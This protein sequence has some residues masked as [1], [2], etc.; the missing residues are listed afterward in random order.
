MDRLDYHLDRELE[1]LA[2]IADG[3]DFAEGLEGFF[4]K[5]PARF[6]RISPLPSGEGK[7]EGGTVAR[8]G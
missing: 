1:E 5:R 8:K 4:E 7:G 3:G 2:R 6:E